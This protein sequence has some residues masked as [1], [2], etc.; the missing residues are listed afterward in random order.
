MIYTRDHIDCY[1]D[2][3][4]GDTYLRVNLANMMRRHQQ[5]HIAQD[6]ESSTP[7]VQDEGIRDA[8]NYLN[9]VSDDDVE[10]ILD[11][12]DLLLIKADGSFHET[13]QP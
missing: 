1:S 8:L 11:S 2:G 13:S 12:G 10:W 9:E 7:E 3:T 4:L 6:I 5:S